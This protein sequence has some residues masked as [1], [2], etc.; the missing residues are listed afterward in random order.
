MPTAHVMVNGLEID[1]VMYQEQDHWIAQGL[2]FD[3]GA[4]ARDPNT[5]M[6]RF[7]A[8]LGAEL[9]VSLELGDECPLASVAPAP[10]EFWDMF[11]KVEE[12]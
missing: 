10:Q 12:I 11:E 1:V 4:H 7:V 5:L 6:S 2:Q 9:V 8:V 3:V